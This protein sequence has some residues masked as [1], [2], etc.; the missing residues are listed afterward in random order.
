[1]ILARSLSAP[2]TKK[3]LKASLTRFSTRQNFLEY[4]IFT[5]R[6]QPCECSH[7]PSTH[8]GHNAA[9][10]PQK[11]RDRRPELAF[12]TP[13]PRPLAGSLASHALADQDNCASARG[14][15]RDWPREADQP[16]RAYLGGLTPCHVGPPLQSRAAAQPRQPRTEEMRALASPQ[17]ARGQRASTGRATKP[18][19]VDPLSYRPSGGGTT[20][21]HSDLRSSSGRMELAWLIIPTTSR[22][23]MPICGVGFTVAG[24][25]FTKPS[26]LPLDAADATAAHSI[27]AS[28]YNASISPASLSARPRNTAALASAFDKRRT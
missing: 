24:A 19:P 17:G 9:S 23:S 8:V 3:L 6:A 15:A 5:P 16:Q 21:H 14:S 22:T 12:R 7:G 4:S 18:S 26:S 10:H 25:A 1:M 28:P 13:P 27:L 2:A 20:N 11:M